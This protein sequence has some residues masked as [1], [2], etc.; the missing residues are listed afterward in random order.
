MLLNIPQIHR[1]AKR[2]VTQ[3]N[4]YLDPGI[5][6]AQRKTKVHTSINCTSEHTYL[7]Y[8]T[9]RIKAFKSKYR[10][11]R[12]HHHHHQQQHGIL[13]CAIPVVRVTN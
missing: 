6:T 3:Q 7:L 8:K 11:R 2:S 10:R 9:E 5:L 13:M 1:P 12:R 4:L